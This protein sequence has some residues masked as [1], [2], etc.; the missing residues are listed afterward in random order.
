[1]PG[2]WEKDGAKEVNLYP[3]LFPLET[4]A[5]GLHSLYRRVAD[6]RISLVTWW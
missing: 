2:M 5:A 4:A 3:C 6:S 1:M